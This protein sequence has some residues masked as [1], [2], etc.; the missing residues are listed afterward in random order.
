LSGSFNP[1]LVNG[2]NVTGGG[3]TPGSAYVGAYPN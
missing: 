3:G 1:P 2:C